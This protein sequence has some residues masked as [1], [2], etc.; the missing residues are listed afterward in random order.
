MARKG[1]LA[2]IQVEGAPQLRRALKKAGDR[3]EDLKAAHRSGAERVADRARSLVPRLDG[4]LARTIKVKATK[5]SAGVVAGGTP[6]VPYAGP[7][8]YGWRARN[9]EPQPFLTDALA[10]ERD[11]IAEE[12]E[13]AA[14]DIVR[15]LDREAP[16]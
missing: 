2:S 7:I 1:G 11:R 15:R 8:H 3:A 12:Y 10:D 14:A 9:I 4:D 13:K 16:D 6:L 5:T